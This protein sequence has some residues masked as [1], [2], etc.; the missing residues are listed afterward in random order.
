ML[1]DRVEFERDFRASPFFSPGEKNSAGV[2]ACVAV[3]PELGVNRKPEPAL[4]APRQNH[5]RLGITFDEETAL[6]GRTC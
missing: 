5:G 1:A 6:L 2:A 3:R 4:P